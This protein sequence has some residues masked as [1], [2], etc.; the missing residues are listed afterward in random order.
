MA[1]K[2][3][4]CRRTLSAQTN[5]RRKKS[6]RNSAS[7]LATWMRVLVTRPVVV[8][9]IAS[10]RQSQLGVK[11]ATSV[12][13]KFTTIE[14]S[15][16]Q[17]AWLVTQFP[18]LR[19]CKAVEL[20]WTE[21]PS[22]FSAWTLRPIARKHLSSSGTPSR[23]QRKT[24]TTYERSLKPERLNTLSVTRQRIFPR[25]WIAPMDTSL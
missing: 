14:L 1:Q 16:S 18:H 7:A 5:F 21:A 20:L 19:T 6:N 12:S 23:R 3:T 15:R 17:T 11:S 4:F 25:S 9:Q 13:T 8:T 22:L 2:V 24:S 10:Q